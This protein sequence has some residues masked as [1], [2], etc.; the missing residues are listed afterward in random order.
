MPSKA[1][2][3]TRSLSHYGRLITDYTGT[4][5]LSYPGGREQPC[6]FAAGQ[7]I[8]GTV[9]LLAGPLPLGFLFNDTAPVAFR[10]TT[11]DGWTVTSGRELYVIN[12]LV[13][14]KDEKNAPPWRAFKMQQLLVSRG[15]QEAGFEARYGITNCKMPSNSSVELKVPQSGEGVVIRRLQNYSRTMVGLQTLRHT[16]VTCEVAVQLSPDSDLDALDEFVAD[17]CY[18]LSVARGTKVSWLYRT[19]VT[20]QSQ[21]VSR[22]HNWHITRPY[23]SWAVIEPGLRGDTDIFLQQAIGGYL[24]RKE[25]YRLDRGT[26]DAYLDAKSESDFLQSRGAKLAVALELLKAAM[27]EA[28]G[29]A[30]KEFILPEAEFDALA[31]ELAQRVDDFLKEKQIKRE[32]RQPLADERKLKGLNRRSFRALLT[33]LN[34]RLGLSLVGNE[35]EDFI[36]SRNSLV[37]TGRFLCEREGFGEPTER[38]GRS[39]TEEYCFLL[40]VLDRV[41]LKLL[42]YSGPYLDWSKPG[43]IQRRL[44]P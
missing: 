3:T 18:V 11:S 34:K 22:E 23:G 25:Q 26:I 8:D 43:D 37:H 17:L 1:S 28:E 10:G 12:L 16:D 39:V 32:H 13:D 9:V 44:L 21:I 36:A 41:F 15:G 2:P 4:G 24:A 14:E 31:P 35:L 19:V 30:I 29:G 33:T 42:G 27:I 5:V 6:S 38:Q 7:F 20:N 40:H